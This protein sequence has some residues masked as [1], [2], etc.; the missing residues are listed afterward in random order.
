MSDFQQKKKIEESFDHVLFTG[1][2]RS[3]STP[4]AKHCITSHHTATHCNALQQ[5]ARPCTNLQHTEAHCNILQHTAPNLYMR[6]RKRL[7]SNKRRKLQRTETPCNTLA[8]TAT[9]R[10]ALIQPV[11]VATR[12]PTIIYNAPMRRLGNRNKS[13]ATPWK[14]TGSLQCVAACHNNIQRSHTAAWQPQQVSCN[15]TETHRCVAMCCSVLQCIA[16]C[17]NNIQRA[18]AAALH[19]GVLQ[20]VAVCRSVLQCVAA[21]ASMPTCV[22]AATH[23]STLQ[24][25]AAHCN[26][27]Q[28]TAPVAAA[29]RYRFTQPYSNKLQHTATHC[30]T[31]HQTSPVAA[32]RRWRF[33]RS[34]KIITNNENMAPA[35][36]YSMHNQSM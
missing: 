6:R 13:P 33:T 26:T 28:H 11:N 35:M 31:L 10:N 5:T 27:L 32:A 9:Q 19:T 8:H 29:R 25:T 17:H 22:A 2:Q 18:D 14:H 34:I 7:R 20:C 15:N 36:T 21:L 12:A 3:H 4:N 23:C 24:H 1:E 16:A 30:N